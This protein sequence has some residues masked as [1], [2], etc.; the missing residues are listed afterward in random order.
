[1]STPQTSNGVQTL[2]VDAISESPTNPRKTFG[3]LAELDEIERS[4]SLELKE[5]QL[6][7]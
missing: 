1:M 2:P 3:D 5:A 4:N 7:G 6:D